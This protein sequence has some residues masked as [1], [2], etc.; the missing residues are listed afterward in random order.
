LN[1]NIVREIGLAKGLVDIKVCAIDDVWSGLKFVI[2]K[3][4]RRG[5]GVSSRSGATIKKQK[6][7]EQ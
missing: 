1:E 5:D 7:L 2:R 6:S 3:Q 4:N